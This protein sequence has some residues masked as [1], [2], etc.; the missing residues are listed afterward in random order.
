MLGRECTAQGKA[1]VLTWLMTND[2]P[3][4]DHLNNI[5]NYANLSKVEKPPLV[6]NGAKFAAPSSGS[7]LHGLPGDYL[8]LSRF[9]RA[10]LLSNSAPTNYS[11][12]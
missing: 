2:P 9:I 8:S 12:S 11:S 1:D 5:G 7:G 3:F 10:L 6:I 4:Q